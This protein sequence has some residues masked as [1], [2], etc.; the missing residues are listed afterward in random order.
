MQIRQSIIKN[1]KVTT[2][3][4]YSM[5][6]SN[7]RKAITTVCGLHL[8]NQLQVIPALMKTM[9]AADK[10]YS[11]SR[12]YPNTNA[13]LVTRKPARIGT[14]MKTGHVSRL[15]NCYLPISLSTK[16]RIKSLP[17]TSQTVRTVLH[18]VMHRSISPK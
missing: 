14:T 11:P 12:S 16:T 1:M 15:L 6:V 17:T 18:G 10:M 2:S 13:G 5:I 4:Q 3:T 9:Y 8:K 7:S